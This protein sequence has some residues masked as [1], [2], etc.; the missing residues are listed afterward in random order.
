V[1]P[2]GLLSG[3]ELMGLPLLRAISSALSQ[4]AN[5]ERLSGLKRVIGIGSPDPGAGMGGMSVMGADSAG[6]SVVGAACAG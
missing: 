1:L 4:R 5:P 3:H 2:S 6:I